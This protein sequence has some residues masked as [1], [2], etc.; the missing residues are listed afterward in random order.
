MLNF[1]QDAVVSPVGDRVL[2]TSAL[3]RQRRLGRRPYSALPPVDVGQCPLPWRRSGPCTPSAGSG[4]AQ[5]GLQASGAGGK[6]SRG[7]AAPLTSAFPCPADVPLRAASLGAG[8]LY[9]EHIPTSPLQKA[10]LAAG[11]AGMALYNPYRHGKAARARGSR[12][13]WGSG[14]VLASEARAGPDLCQSL[15]FLCVTGE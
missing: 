4:A 15:G 5:G 2:L 6:D 3:R 10:L 14:R 12:G 13:S 8:R 1:Y 11:S 7:R 9:P